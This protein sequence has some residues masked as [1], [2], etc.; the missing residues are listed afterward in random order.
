VERITANTHRYLK[1]FCEAIDS[2]VPAATVD[3]D[4]ENR[5]DV[6]DVLQLQREQQLAQVC[7]HTSVQ[8]VISLLA[9][10]LDQVLCCSGGNSALCDSTCTD[11]Y[12]SVA[13]AHCTRT[14]LHTIN[15]H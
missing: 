10:I 9:F 6:W 2:A 8:T 11:H 14:L 5:R 15:L 1:L 13:A 3:L 7:I 12:L 4:A